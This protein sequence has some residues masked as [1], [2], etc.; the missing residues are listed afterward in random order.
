[1]ERDSEVL[2]SLANHQG[3][4]WDDTSHLFV[5][6]HSKWSFNRS[7]KAYFLFEEIGLSGMMFLYLRKRSFEFECE[8]GGV[9]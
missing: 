6:H 2:P 5:S 3:D 8:H 1:M 7:L 4:D 9:Y